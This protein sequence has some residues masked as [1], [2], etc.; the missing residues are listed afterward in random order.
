MLISS[1]YGV[2]WS[3]VFLY[4][5]YICVTDGPITLLFLGDSSESLRT[6]SIFYT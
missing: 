1:V 4:L 5:I 2:F 3:C 6:A